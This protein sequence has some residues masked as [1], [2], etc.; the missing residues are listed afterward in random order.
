M[1]ESWA[2]PSPRNSLL[3]AGVNGAA[4][5]DV[6]T[7]TRDLLILLTMTAFLGGCFGGSESQQL[8]ET[9]AQP[10]SQTSQGT[11]PCPVTP[12]NGDIPPGETAHPQSRFFGNGDLW[13][14]LYPNPLR[15][16]PEDVR[17]N[18][19]IAIKYP[20]WRGVS[21][22]L[23]ITGRR[24]DATAPAL[25]AHVPDG[26]GRKGF[27]STAIVFPT[28]GC[29]EVTGAVGDVSLTFVALVAEPR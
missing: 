20:W 26:Y 27:Q 21:G 10:A 17:M 11:E 24:L 15:P 8:S 6:P 3:T 22:R 23:A 25:S 2:S 9:D 14:E 29:W 4:A 7:V 13:I 16:R 28:P 18:G 19:R 5:V 12:P 1:V